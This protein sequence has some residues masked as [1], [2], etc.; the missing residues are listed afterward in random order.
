[1]GSTVILPDG[2]KVRHHRPFSHVIA[3]GP[4]ERNTFLAKSEE[5]AFNALAE[6]FIL[7]HVAERGEV[8]RDLDGAW[9]AGYEDYRIAHFGREEVNSF[10]YVPESLDTEPEP[11]LGALRDILV[12]H[13]EHAVWM[14]ERKA[15]MTRDVAAL[16]D[17]SKALLGTWQVAKWCKT[18][19]AAHEAL[20]A[21]EARRDWGAEIRIIPTVNDR[22]LDLEE[23]P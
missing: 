20:P 13:T 15:R 8:V 22:V 14:L 16:V 12:N 19:D 18:A 9:L 2:T 5:V 11:R 6:A 10:F 21:Y 1:M 4:C 17:T 23:A 3:Q 7:R